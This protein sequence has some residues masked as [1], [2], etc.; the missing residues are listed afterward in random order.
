VVGRGGGFDFHFTP[1]GANERQDQLQIKD[2]A[3]TDAEDIDLDMD[4]FTIKTA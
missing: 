4:Y 1:C 2:S 3:T